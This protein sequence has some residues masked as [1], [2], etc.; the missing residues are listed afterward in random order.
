MKKLAAA[1]KI[2]NKENKNRRFKKAK[3]LISVALVG[4]MMVFCL[5]GCGKSVKPDYSSASKFEKDLN[6]GKNLK[7]KTVAL[8]VDEIKPDSAFGYDIY[9]GDH[10]NFVSEDNPDVKKGDKI[11]VKAKKIKSLL[12]SWIISY[13]KVE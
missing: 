12:G 3:M 11:I 1:Q 8:T 2:T 13:E 7:D 10:L 6:D 4:V 5:A 9:A